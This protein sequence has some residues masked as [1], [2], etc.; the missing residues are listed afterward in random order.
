M[1]LIGFGALLVWVYAGGEGP[2]LS[3]STASYSLGLAGFCMLA[4]FL[5]GRAAE[6]VARLIIDVSVP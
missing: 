2:V 6:R 5:A 3:V 1:G 4:G